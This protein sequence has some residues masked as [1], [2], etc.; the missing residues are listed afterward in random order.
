MDDINEK[1]FT[2]LLLYITFLA[3]KKQKQ[4]IVKLKEIYLS[5]FRETHYT[6]AESMMTGTVWST[7][8]N[9]WSL[10]QKSQFM[11]PKSF[12]IL[13][14]KLQPMAFNGPG[15]KRYQYYKIVMQIV[16][17]FSITLEFGSLGFFWEIF[18][19]RFFKRWVAN[20]KNCPIFDYISK[21]LLCN[22]RSAIGA[23]VLRKLEK[24]AKLNRWVNM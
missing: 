24:L 23:G 5:F 22:I 1:Q 4:K 11:W 8:R 16:D 10:K 21:F 3:V 18:I 15:Q 9:R 17:R 7:E 19:I 14:V 2:F 20:E 13:V 6:N 12:Q